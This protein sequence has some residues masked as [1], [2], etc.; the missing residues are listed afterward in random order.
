MISRGMISD[1]R[2]DIAGQTVEVGDFGGSGLN[3][4]YIAPDQATVERL[5]ALPAK[6][7]TIS[8]PSA[9]WTVKV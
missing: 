1:V 8:A 3:V 7:D 4:A 2:I 9:P 6:V 5:A